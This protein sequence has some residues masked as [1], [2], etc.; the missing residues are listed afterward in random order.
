MLTRG[1]CYIKH[2]HSV[3]RS[4]NRHTHSRN[5]LQRHWQATAP[6]WPLPLAICH[7]GGARGCMLSCKHPRHAA[8]EQSAYILLCPFFVGSRGPTKWEPWLDSCRGDQICPPCP[9]SHGN[10]RTA[11]YVARQATFRSHS[12]PTRHQ[13]PLHTRLWAPAQAIPC[14][15]ALRTPLECCTGSDR[16]DTGPVQSKS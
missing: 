7:P 6:A 13:P 11:E 3:K 4:R 14:R 5:L 12:C 2:L 15:A 16:P 9:C 1:H 8:I 10:L